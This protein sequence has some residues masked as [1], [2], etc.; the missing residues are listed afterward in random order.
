MSWPYGVAERRSRGKARDN[1]DRLD[2]FRCPCERS[3]EF[4]EMFR[5]RQVTKF[6]FKKHQSGSHLPLYRFPAAHTGPCSETPVICEDLRFSARSVYRGT[7]LDTP[8]SMY[9]LPPP[10]LGPVRPRSMD[11]RHLVGE[12]SRA[13]GPIHGNSHTFPVQSYQSHPPSTSIATLGATKHVQNS[14]GYTRTALW[15]PYTRGE[16]HRSMRQC[17][18]RRVTTTTSQKAL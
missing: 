17:G 6:R 5:D 14:L 10:L 15:T 11:V 4:V 3:S 7:R 9:A 2:V 1:S 16:E 13:T 8:A 12:S 18:G